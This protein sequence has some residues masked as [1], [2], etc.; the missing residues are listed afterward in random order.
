MIKVE[1]LVFAYPGAPAPTLEGLNFE[2]E[3]G[4]VLGFLGP[5]GA[6]KSTTQRIL[7][8]LLEGYRGRAEVMGK[9]VR[10]WGPD[11]YETIGVSF[12]LPNHHQRLTALENLQHFGALYRGP[13]VDP[14][15]V[16]RWVDLQDHA[17]KRVTDFSKGMK[18]RLNVARSLLHRPKLLFLDE[19]TSGL[20]PVNAK[21]VK[22]L[23]RRLQREGTTVFVTTHDM[24]V[25]E[26]L[27]DRVAFM[28]DGRIAA[29]DTPA[30]LEKSFG[31]RT[32]AVESLDATGASHTETFPLDGLGGD[33]RFLELLRSGARI[34]T[35]HS[36][37]TTLENMFIEVT[38]QRL[39]A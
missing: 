24:S 2:I 5:S 8:G 4:E 22:D 37:E 30:A 26:S 10:D 33:T 12:E 16:L 3:D 6:G 27:C 19:P 17:D 29:L 32:V 38:G 13:L 20:D 15:E 31:S 7:I 28:C 11:Y 1:N 21:R 36:Q 34:E 14:M 9:E 35:I 18:I 23:V 39:D 25:A